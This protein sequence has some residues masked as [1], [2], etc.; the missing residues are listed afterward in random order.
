MPKIH[1]PTRELRE[2]IFG[3]PLQPVVVKELSK[4]TKIPISTL[5]GYKKDPDKIPLGKLR[6]ICR[7]VHIQPELAE[8]ILL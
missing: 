5:C 7:A 6:I 2:L 1:D 4:K 3:T 8:K